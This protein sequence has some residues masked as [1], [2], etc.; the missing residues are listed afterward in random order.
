VIYWQLAAA[1]TFASFAVITC[2][3]S[4]VSALTAN[5]LGRL[6]DERTQRSRAAG[7][8]VLR[9][10]P[11]VAGLVGA[12]AIVLPLFLWFEPS[13]T[14][15]SV[16]KTL[17]V[18]GA[19]GALWLALGAWRAALAWRAT[20]A[21]AREWHGRGRRL[22][23]FDVPI[24]VFAIDETYP[25]VA[26]VGFRRPELFISERVLRACSPDEVHAMILHECAHAAAYDNTKRFVLR[27]C[28]PLLSAN[29][30]LDTLWAHATEEAADAAATRSRP[31]LRT[32]L[33]HALVTIARLATVT[34]PPLPVS[35]LYLGGSI[36]SRVRRLLAP[37][38]PQAPPRVRISVV[39]LVAIVTTIAA[40]IMF[41]STLHSALEAV[42]KFL[43]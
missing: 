5:A 39:S 1:I 10:L 34:H 25:M 15:E 37:P 14:Q 29:R 17:A 21:L 40:A 28:P 7:L 2:V 41:G 32:D 9:L 43:P 27:A 38:T 30:S 36:E 33:A 16:A 8:L 12:F 3:A 6:V 42:V 31:G 19:A 13:D 11:F 24:P 18:L 20:R 26:V 22:D 4:V 23:T 35:A